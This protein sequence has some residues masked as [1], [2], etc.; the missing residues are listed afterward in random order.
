MGNVSCTVNVEDEVTHRVKEK[1][2][3]LNTIKKEG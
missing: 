2:N 3:I 1:K